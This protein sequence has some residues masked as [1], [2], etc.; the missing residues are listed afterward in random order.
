LN[1]VVLDSCV[2]ING[3]LNSNVECSLL[4][5]K[6]IQRSL[7][8]FI[9][10][11]GVAEVINVLRRLSIESEVSITFLE[12]NFWS[13]LNLENVV[14]DFNHSI[15]TSLRSEIKNQTE[16]KM[17]AEAM[18]LQPKDVPIVLLAYKHKIPLLTEDYRSLLMK[19][20]LVKKLVKIEIYSVKKW[21]SLNL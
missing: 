10:S 9:S 18:Q 21:L 8:A 13:L 19:R 12:R 11:Y 7:L 4:I 14:T 3:M 17:L 20:D 16:I 6:L 15:T 1:G 5:N 2:W